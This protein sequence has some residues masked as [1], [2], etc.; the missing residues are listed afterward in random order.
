MVKKFT[1]LTVAALFAGSAFAFSANSAFNNDKALRHNKSN[2]KHVSLQQLLSDHQ[3]VA[4]KSAR[5]VSSADVIYDAFGTTKY[6]NKDYEGDMDGQA[7]ESSSASKIV[8]G[9][10]NDVYFYDILS[11]AGLGTYTKG[12]MSGETITVELPQLA[13]FS[14]DYGYGY[15]LT[16][17]KYNSIKKQFRPVEGSVEFDVF[18]DGTLVLN[19]PGDANEYALG[20]I[21]TD[22]EEYAGL[23]EFSMVYEPADLNIATI[24]EDVTLETY[25]YND[26]VFGYPVQVGFDANNLYIQGLCYDMGKDNVIVGSLNGNTAEVAQDQCLGVYGGYFIYTKC[27]VLNDAM[28][29]FE[30]DAD[31]A[32][33][34]LSVDRT[35]KVI[36]YGEDTDNYLIFN[37]ALDEVYYLTFFEDLYINTQETM[38]GTPQN[39]F[40]LYY[41]DDYYEWYGYYSFMF[42]V[43]NVSTEGN[44]LDNNCLYYRVYIDGEL[45]EF[46]PDENY[47]MYVDLPAPT[48][49]VPFDFTNDNDFYFW[50]AIDREV[51]IY[52]ENISTI[53]VQSVYKYNGVTT[54][55][56]IITIDAT[57]VEAIFN[58]ADVVK[59]EYFDLNGRRILNPAKGI[60]IS[61]STMSDG[62]VKTVKV[63]K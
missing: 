13:Y 31:D 48:T 2:A 30:L 36:S 6:Y 39:P 40:D 22:D 29:D 14:D 47:W 38:A 19:L 33:C 45:Y 55:S 28:D 10:N 57:A 37:A 21:Y 34:K 18:D 63:V 49:E 23:A 17:L 60:C 8:F 46:V 54:E 50:G 51:G 7:Y 12:T 62:S 52:D 43:P 59:T 15:E 11:D 42:S 58:N 20:F 4:K 26:G 1:L 44:V 53:G 27:V 24:P 61:R 32:V 5:Q 41:T 16:L 25:Y 35:N 3:G 56:D 9:E